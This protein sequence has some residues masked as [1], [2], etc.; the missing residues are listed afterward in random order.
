MSEEE[1]EAGK[2]WI[3]EKIYKIADEFHISIE[4]SAW[5]ERSN[6]LGQWSLAIVAVCKR[7]VM[8]LKENDLADCLNT[9]E[10]RLEMENS[11]KKFIK[12]FCP[13]KKKIGF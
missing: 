8:K 9:K 4:K 6:D 13:Q 3:I 7:K 12:S 5:D 11:L 2:N 10:V 1:I